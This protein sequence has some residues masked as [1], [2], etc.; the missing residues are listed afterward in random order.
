MLLDWL[1]GQ[2]LASSSQGDAEGLEQH[3]R[4]DDLPK[5]TEVYHHVRDLNDQCYKVKRN[6]D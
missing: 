5:D 1:D 2:S 3:P 6:S 4:G